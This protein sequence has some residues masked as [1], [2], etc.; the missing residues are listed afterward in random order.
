MKQVFL[1]ILI[2]ISGCSTTIEPD[3]SILGED[4]IPLETGDFHIF[5][6]SDK[7]YNSDGS[8]DSTGY[9]L[10]EEISDS[11]LAPDE[12]YISYTINRFR[13]SLIQDDWSYFETISR[14]KNSQHVSTVEGNVPVISFSFPVNEGRTWDGNSQNDMPVDYFEQKNLGHPFTVDSLIF[15]NT[16]HVFQEE[17]IDS[18]CVATDDYRLEVYAKEVGMVYRRYRQVRYIDW[19]Q[20]EVEQCTVE[21]GMDIEQKLV[22]FGKE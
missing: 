9:F 16:V 13:K 17:L 14:R 11:T 5:S 4:F 10:R 12:R 19:T 22:S 8:I 20:N 21:S 18:L 2:L 7:R 6:I 15:A 3:F 1:G